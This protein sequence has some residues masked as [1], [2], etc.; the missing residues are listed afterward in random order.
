MDEVDKPLDWSRPLWATPDVNIANQF[1]ET[2]DLAKYLRLTLS[3]QMLYWQRSTT[4]AP[5]SPRW[6]GLS[7]FEE[8]MTQTRSSCH[9]CARV[10]G[11]RSKK[12]KEKSCPSQPYSQEDNPPCSHL[13]PTEMA[14]HDR[15]R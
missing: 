3:K 14:T 13:S 10:S 8:S 12:S 4:I 15:S 2:L 1:R 9:V 5:K 11:S 6:T 7:H